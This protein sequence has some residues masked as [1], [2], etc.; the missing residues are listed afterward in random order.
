MR[1]IRFSLRTL[2]LFSLTVSAAM[3]AG[4]S[5]LPQV[6]GAQII[7]ELKDLPGGVRG[8]GLEWLAMTK[9]GKDL[10]KWDEDVRSLKGLGSVGV[11]LL[12]NSLNCQD[13][14]EKEMALI[15]LQSFGPDAAEAVPLLTAMLDEED[16]WV[17]RQVVGCLGKIGYQALP[18]LSK[19][20]QLLEERKR[21]YEIGRLQVHFMSTYSHLFEPAHTIPIFDRPAPYVQEVTPEM[22]RFLD[23]AIGQISGA[24]KDVNEFAAPRTSETNPGTWGLPW[25]VRLTVPLANNNGKIVGLV[26]AILFGVLSVWS[27]LSDRRYFRKLLE[28]KQAASAGGMARC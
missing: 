2:L 14:E 9:S 18:A 19:L 4:L 6:W 21:D 22:M 11:H 20:E 24:T 5:S 16:Y 27:F 12:C 1:V 13:S 7:P 10:A 15:A 23:K 17:L 28:A 25:Y 8:Y 26:L 3:L